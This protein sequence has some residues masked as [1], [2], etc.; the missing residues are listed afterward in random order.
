MTR[1]TLQP[2]PMVI[3]AKRTFLP[4]CEATADQIVQQI[5]EH[6]PDKTRQVRKEA[7]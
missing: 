1:R 6:F 5:I 3:N 4:R 2:S 7:A